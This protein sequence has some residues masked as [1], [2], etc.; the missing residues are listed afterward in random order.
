MLHAR[1][2]GPGR[3]WDC[4]PYKSIAAAGRMRMSLQQRA[5]PVISWRWRR[6]RVTCEHRQADA[7]LDGHWHSAGAKLEPVNRGRKTDWVAD[8]LRDV[9]RRD[10]V[11]LVM[12]ATQKHGD[13]NGSEEDSK[14]CCDNWGHYVD[15]CCRL[16]RR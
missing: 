12:S 9:G 7:L 1:G 8:D 10:A 16:P 13:A 14:G 15:I 11:L 3:G 5:A 2:G 4:G 6:A